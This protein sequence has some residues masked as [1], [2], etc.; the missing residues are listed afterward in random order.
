MDFLGKVINFVVLLGGL[1]YFLRNP[2]RNFLQARTKSFEDAL[3]ETKNSRV[4][5]E[6]RLQDVENRL[7]RIDREIEQI[8]KQAETEGHAVEK[9]ILQDAKAGANRLKLLSQREI[10]RLTQAGI[11][12]IRQYAAELATALALQRIQRRINKEDQSL[13]IDRSIERLEKLYEKSSPSQE[14]R[15]RAH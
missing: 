3:R 4:E 5:A 12:Q 15:T 2:L 6:K 14:I 8:Q 9:R 11:R 10:E 13:L 7:E 1:I